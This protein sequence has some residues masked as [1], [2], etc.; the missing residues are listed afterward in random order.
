MCDLPVD[1]MFSIL[2][3]AKG[4]ATRVVVRIRLGLLLIVLATSSVTAA[5]G[6]AAGNTAPQ[7][8]VHLT[9]PQRAFSVGESVPVKIHIENVGN[10]PVL[11]P[12]SV[13]VIHNTNAHIEVELRDTHGRLSPSL[14]ATA[15]NFP[16]RVPSSPAI[17][18]LRSWL[19]LWPKSSLV[20]D[21]PIDK[22]LFAFL[23]KP[24]KYRLSA[25]YSS[26]GLLYSHV[27]RDIGL[28]D[29]EVQSLPF[30]SWSGHISTNTLDFEIVPAKA[31]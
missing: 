26:N 29:E 19:L 27:Y 14:M 4:L 24:G 25:V 12:N 21:L 3:A 31:K 17:A 9:I 10:K 22:E 1:L 28:T 8:S 18:L 23:G 16:P 7:I 15:E 6:G 20:V 5:Q 30:Q 13:S 11:I 2:A